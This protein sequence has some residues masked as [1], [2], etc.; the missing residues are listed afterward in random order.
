M[1]FIHAKPRGDGAAGVA[2]LL[3]GTSRVTLAEGSPAGD[4]DVAMTFA[5]TP[6][7]DEGICCCAWTPKGLCHMVIVISYQYI[8]I[9]IWSTVYNRRELSQPAAGLRPYSMT[10]PE[11]HQMGHAI[12]SIEC[13]QKHIYGVFQ[14]IPTL[15][16]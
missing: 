9:V 5:A 4:T 1:S 14:L 10:S 2:H 3:T 13:M 6:D 12:L 15:A 11:R 16:R 8:M 7:A